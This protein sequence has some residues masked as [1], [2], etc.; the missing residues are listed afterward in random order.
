MKRSIEG[1]MIKGH[2]E[3]LVLAMLASGEPMHAYRIRQ[4]LIDLSNQVLH[5]SLGRLYPLLKNM[6][7]KGWLTSR[8]ETVCERRERTAYRITAKGGAELIVQK[9][10]W[11]LFSHSVDRVLKS[12]D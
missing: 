5:P 2:T 9:K 8:K 12:T 7:K 1:E 3:L 4:D 10:R 6:V 11:E